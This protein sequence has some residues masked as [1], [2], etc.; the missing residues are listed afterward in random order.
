M[1]LTFLIKENICSAVV[2]FPFQVFKTMDARLTSIYKL[3]VENPSWRMYT[4]YKFSIPQ[5]GHQ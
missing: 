2:E 1:F 4:R 5:R 3:D